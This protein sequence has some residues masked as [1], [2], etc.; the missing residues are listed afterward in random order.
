MIYKLVFGACSF[1]L[2]SFIST[3]LKVEALTFERLPIVQKSN[4]W[5]VQVGEAEKGKD[6]VE[7]VKGKFHTYS[8]KI[9]KIGTNV[10]SLYIN[11]YRNEPNS[12]RKYDLHSCPPGM[13]CNENIYERAVGLAK[14]MN[15]GESYRHSNFLLAEKAT[16]LEVEIIWTENNQGRPLKETFI[17]TE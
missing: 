15:N 10:D 13:E 11:L 8:L 12:I 9:D 3:S 14:A 6:L 16:E 17:F 1:I 7:P 4:Q 5:S 2:L